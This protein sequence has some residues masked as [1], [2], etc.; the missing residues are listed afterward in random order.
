MPHD[1]HT[2]KKLAEAADAIKRELPE[3]WRFYLVCYPGRNMEDFHLISNI[4]KTDLI[5][6][7]REF[8]RNT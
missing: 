5:D 8:L 1:E 4:P 6:S 2:R 7:M 3:D